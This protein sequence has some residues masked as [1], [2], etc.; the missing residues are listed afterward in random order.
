MAKSHRRPSLTAP[1]WGFSVAFEA[2]VCR[3][4][5]GPG[6]GTGDGTLWPGWGV[7]SRPDTKHSVS[8][9]DSF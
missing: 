6:S 8:R 2:E 3:K 4:G 1:A 7:Y 5:W 9:E